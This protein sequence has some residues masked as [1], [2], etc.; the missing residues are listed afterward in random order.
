MTMLP[1]LPTIPGESLTSYLNRVAK[2]HADMD[3]FKFLAFIELS[4]GAVMA[5]KEDAMG[6]LSFLLGLP[7]REIERM[8]FV[9]LGGRMRSFCGEEVHSEFANL[10]KTSYC[11][12]CLLE[13]GKSDSLSAGFRVGRI[14]WRIE[15]IRTCEAHGIGLVRR[16][17]A[18]HTEKFQLM[19]AVAPADD[20]LCSMVRNAPKQ[21]VSAL[22]AYL[23]ERLAGKAG[24]T[25]L[26]GQ[27]IDLAARA[28]EMLGVIISAGTHVNLKLLTDA[29]WNEAGHVGFSYAARGEAGITEALQLI[30]D[31][32]KQAGLRG[33]PQKVFGRLYQWLQY[34]NT[35]KAVG[36]IRD[37]V[38]EFILDNLPVE[39][40]SDLFGEAVGRQRVHSI[41]SLA[42]LTAGHH[43]TIN[44]AMILAGLLDGDPERPS[45]N[46][47]FDAE[48]GECLME[49]IRTSIPVKRL[50]G[51][52]NCNRV[53]AE[54]L[55]RTGVIPRL[56]PNSENAIGVLKQVA[57]EDADA[58]LERLMGAA[59]ETE[60]A[61]EGVMDIVSAS[62][63]ARWPVIDVVN[64][65]LAGLFGTVELVDPSLKFKGILV[66]PIEVR[67][68]LSREKSEGRVG[69]DEGA[70]IIGMPNH[71]LSALVKMRNA[72]GAPYVVEYFV[73][74]S[75]GTTVRLFDVESL[76]S[77][78]LDHVSLKEIAE[79]QSFS[80]K[81]MK[82]KL[83]AH[84]VLP[85][86]PKYE[87]GRVWYRRKD[88][89]IF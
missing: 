26:D 28:C 37:L 79:Q 86:A 21:K 78:R 51:Y 34:S 39:V 1:A 53:Q 19:S 46:N 61:S 27:P 14:H 13:D 41:H 80:T 24:P 42:K 68:T 4:Q 59:T 54:Q 5:P 30:M 17:N 52:F 15:H 44:R 35:N 45:A 69:L 57:L 8:T 31:R 25:W 36:P 11:P 47:V 75:K 70:R 50:Q 74:N 84:G 6:R 65:I 29:E 32:F 87:L 43:K 22:Q 77:F 63:I 55:V 67:E 73:E 2:F 10:D 82:M 71:G 64:G 60:L 85:L 49:R 12:A 48:A 66:D 81:V 38:R 83:D 7:S 88:L 33:G 18:N 16:K 20:A 62:E 76:E 72:D 23:T 9:P 56:V 3:V 58:F 40:G 89:P